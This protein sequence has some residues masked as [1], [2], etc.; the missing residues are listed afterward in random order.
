MTASDGYATGLIT[1]VLQQVGVPRD[2]VQVNDGLSWLVRN[3]TWWGGRWEAYSLNEWHFD[4]FP[5]G[6]H[7]M[8]DAATAYAVLALTQ[9]DDGRSSAQHKRRCLT[10]TPL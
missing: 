8:D 1:Y 2:N 10:D 7:F 6:F 9:A 3:Q 5:V 4:L